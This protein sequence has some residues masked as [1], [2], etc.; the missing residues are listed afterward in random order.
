MDVLKYSFRNTSDTL[1][2]YQDKIVIRQ[3]ST[4]SNVMTSK[5]GEKTIFYHDITSVHFKKF[6][7]LTGGYIQFFVKGHDD[8]ENIMQLGGSHND[9]VAEKIYTYVNSRIMEV[10]SNRN[11]SNAKTSVVSNADEIRKF[12][13]LMDDGIITRA[14]FNAKKKQLLGL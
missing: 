6:S 3:R 10:R 8:D 12:K 14:E 4:L 11:N 7:L 13:K 1:Y 2:V 9:L 5:I